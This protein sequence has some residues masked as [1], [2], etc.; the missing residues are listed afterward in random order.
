ME[1]T[2]HLYQT[3]VITAEMGM[4][5]LSARVRRRTPIGRLAV[6]QGLLTV[7]EVMTVLQLQADHNTEVRFGEAAVS[8]GLLTAEELD[9]LLRS[10]TRAMPSEESLLREMT[11]VT[12]DNLRAARAE[13]RLRTR[14]AA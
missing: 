5:V 6:D 7:K 4:Q 1:L 10:Q 14:S 9:W 2:I 3:G 13:M 8:M 11:Q 12:E